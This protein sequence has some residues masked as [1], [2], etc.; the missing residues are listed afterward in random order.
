M[1]SPIAA[2]RS[3]PRFA[4]LSPAEARE[5]VLAVLGAVREPSEGMRE[6]WS[7]A[8]EAADHPTEHHINS[9]RWAAAIDALVAEVQE[10][11]R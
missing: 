8:E 4:Y 10:E 2:V 7:E 3:L 6:A 11:G 9:R 1:T 5:V